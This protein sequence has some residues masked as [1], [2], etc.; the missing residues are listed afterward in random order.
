MS[1]V[2]PSCATH[3]W[4]ESCQPPS[5][6]IHANTLWSTVYCLQMLAID[7]NSSLGS[8][9]GVMTFSFRQLMPPCLLIQ[10]VM[11]V[12]D[13]RASSLLFDDDAVASAAWKPDRFGHGMTT[14]IEFAVTPWSVLPAGLLQPT[15][16]WVPRPGP[17][18][19]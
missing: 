8:Y 9:S 19:P 5:P 11:A 17:I 12:I 16:P 2:L 7:P 10:F 14:V 18:T 1:G 6:S 15:G 3:N 13:C 4:A